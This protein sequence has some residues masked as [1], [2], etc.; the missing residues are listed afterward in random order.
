MVASLAGCKKRGLGGQCF[1]TDHC[2]PCGMRVIARLI[3]INNSIIYEN[4]P[5]FNIAIGNTQMTILTLFFDFDK[6]GMHYN[7]HPARDASLCSKTGGIAQT[8]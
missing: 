3:I 7:T 4:E 8:L 1:A 5:F 6:L 2:I